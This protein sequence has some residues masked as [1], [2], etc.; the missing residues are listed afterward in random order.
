MY[1]WKHGRQLAS[2]TDG[3][4]TWSYT[5]NADGLRTRRA[6][7]VMVYDYV[8]NG[9]QLTQLTIANRTSRTFHTLYIAYDAS[10]VP[11]SVDY[12]G[13]TY[14]YVTNV[15]GDVIGL[16][17]ANGNS[18]VEYTYDAWGNILST[19]GS[20][21]DTLGAHNPLRYR[22]YVYDS[23]TELYYLQSRYYNPDLG[24]FI[25]ADAFASTGQG[26]LGNNMLAYCRNNPVNSF[27]PNGFCNYSVYTGG[28]GCYRC[29]KEEPFD[30]QGF[31]EST[32]YFAFQIANELVD[33]IELGVGLGAGFGGSVEATIYNIPVGAELYCKSICSLLIG[34]K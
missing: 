13:T 30:L 24:R 27:D 17:D 15:Q 1:T 14:Y 25:N 20:L 4:T 6:G 31:M 12:N 28:Q 5:Y 10:G 19:T 8:Y 29:E 18:V 34:D 3:S 16:L 2:M 23:E 21:K 9:S 22:G 33:N 32:S 7:G 11:M 26:L